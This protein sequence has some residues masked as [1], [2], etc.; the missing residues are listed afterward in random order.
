MIGL[1]TNPDIILGKIKRKMG[2]LNIDDQG[3]SSS[4]RNEDKSTQ[5]SQK[6][7]LVEGFSRELY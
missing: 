5:P 6:Q 3:Y 4:K 1:G 7:I 2:N